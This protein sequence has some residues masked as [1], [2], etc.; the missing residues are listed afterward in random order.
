MGVRPAYSNGWKQLGSL[1]ALADFSWHRVPLSFNGE[2]SNPQVALDSSGALDVE[3][4][5]LNR[6]RYDVIQFTTGRHDFHLVQFPDQSFGVLDS[7]GEELALK[8]PDHFENLGGLPRGTAD[9]GSARHV[10]HFDKVV[11][12]ESYK[13]LALDLGPS[14]QSP[15]HDYLHL[16]VRE[17][18][19]ALPLYY[20]NKDLQSFSA[21][22]SRLPDLLRLNSDRTLLEVSGPY[23][24][25]VDILDF[26]IEKTSAPILWAALNKVF[27][28]PP[29]RDLISPKLSHRAFEY[30]SVISGGPKTYTFR[31]RN[32]VTLANN[33]SLLIRHERAFP[34]L[35]P[36]PHVLLP[37][38]NQRSKIQG[39]LQ[40]VLPVLIQK[41]SLPPSQPLVIWNEALRPAMMES[42]SISQISAWDTF[43]DEAFIISTRASHDGLW[44]VHVRDEESRLYYFGPQRGSSFLKLLGTDCRSHLP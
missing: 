24:I 14:S 31:A 15:G 27:K 17:D 38:L 25:Q 33:L 20:G 29:S 18:G 4:N 13:L 35:W 28:T 8:L 21:E 42:R 36:P 32:E 1:P 19:R 37:S 41:Y 22:D 12:G 34:H 30:F 26:S 7:K 2:N 11:S 10:V 40:H 44:F 6:K 5:S 9:L 16:L 39:D 43:L 3:W 23:Q